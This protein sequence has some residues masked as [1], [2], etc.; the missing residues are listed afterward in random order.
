MYTIK[1]YLCQALNSKMLK[2][3][4][5]TI[6]PLYSSIPDARDLAQGGME[7]PSGKLKESRVCGLLFDHF[8]EVLVGDYLDAQLLRLAEF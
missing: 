6:V 1:N 7:V 2:M 4:T 8:H 5:A 3:E